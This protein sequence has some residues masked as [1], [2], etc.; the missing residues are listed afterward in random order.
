MGIKNVI[1]K[2]A[3][4][5]A[6][7]VAKLSALSPE[8]LEQVQAKREEFLSDFPNMTGA[9][10]EELTNRLLAAN[11]VEIYNAYLPQIEDLY[12]PVEKETEYGED[13]RS[14]NNIRYINITKWVIDKKE[15]SLEKLVNVYEVLSN[16]ACNISLVFHRKVIKT[17]VYLAVTNIDNDDN[18]VDI[19]SYRRRL[20]S[21]IQGN[22]P[23]SSWKE[24]IGRG[25]LPCFNNN[26][27][28]SVATASNV[29]TEKSE[30]FVSQTIEKLLDGIIPA[31]A[32]QE[33]ILVLLA[34][35]IQ[36]ITERKLI[37]SQIYSDLAPYASWQTNYTYTEADARG[38]AATVGI[39]VGASAG[40]QTGTNST[41]TDTSEQTDTEGI[42]DTESNSS[43]E[44]TTKTSGTNSSTTD[45]VGGSFN[46]SIKYGGK[47][48]LVSGSTSV[49]V[50]ASRARTIGKSLS[51]VFSKSMTKGTSLAKTASKAVS[52][53]TALATGASK[54]LNFSMNFGA[55]FARTSNVTAT[56][57]KNEGITQSF[58]NH[59]IKH[60]LELLEEQMKRL[61]KS[62]ALGMWDFAAYILSEDQTVAN[63]VA[64]S[65]L[66]LTQG[67]ESHMSQTVVNLWR[68]DVQ[69]EQAKANE[70]FGYLKDLRHPMFA[71][72][73]ELLE[74]DESFSVYP[75][76]VTATTALSGK[77]LAYSLNFPQKSIAG[78]PVFECAEF[79]RNINSYEETEGDFVKLGKI[80]HMN[81]TEQLD[82]K[83]SLNSLASHTFISGSTGTG[84]SNTVYEILGE[85]RKHGVKFL[86]VEPAKGEYK[87]IF[88][89]DENVSVYG[90]NPELSDL[91]RI[92]PFAFPKGIHVLEHLDRLIEIFNVCW[93]M[94]AAMPA[95]LKNAVERAYE[96]SGW[97]L[98]KSINSYGDL[99]PT[100]A[101][102]TRNI[103]EIIDS[104]EYDN[105]N[106]G[107]Y[108]GS[109][110][111]RLESLTNGI[112]G[113][114][115]TNQAITDKELFDENVII[116]LSRVGS[117]ETKSLIMG[118]LVLKL[119]EYRMTHTDSLNNLLKH[120]TVLEEA[121][122]ILKRTSNEQSM[123]DSNLV[124]KSVEMIANGI[125][126][127]RTYG[128]GFIIAD[129]A[130]GLM[131][132]AVIRNTNTKIIMRLPDFSD[133]ELVGKSA[134]LND[135]Q[136][137]ELA[138][139]PKGVAALY[140]N[141]WIEPILCK[142]DQFNGLENCFEYH[143]QV[144]NPESH[145]SRDI[146]VEYLSSKRVD[147]QI[148]KE[149]N[150]KR[151]LS[152]LGIDS[153]TVR[154][155][156]DWGR[157]PFSMHSYS[158]IVSQ[159]YP[160]LLDL[161]RKQS[162]KDTDVAT[163]TDTLQ[164]EINNRVSDLL[165]EQ[166]KRDL[167][168]ATMTYYYLYELKNNSA[169][170]DWTNNGGF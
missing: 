23:G 73:P 62:T 9:E 160:E 97:D 87:H 85:V 153:L 108:K 124:G 117:T 141:E 17:D 84:K 133:R 75:A 1:R 94:Y 170:Q 32:Q 121:H 134:N 161:L 99:Y 2:V 103:K 31:T 39:N 132:M 131:D 66:A 7:T 148:L 27:H 129:Q 118:M 43:T 136:I 63:N 65:Y 76:V 113:M 16:D 28:Y 112:N 15:N 127:M 10:T 107:A 70:I 40:T 71:L 68:G 18:N 109:L 19:E 26:A 47:G 25:K 59:N 42:T 106:K 4:K 45:T 37:L 167:L 157:E 142:I 105:E 114:I 151:F 53:S 83:I 89:N 46:Q 56:I 158:Q 6:D 122:N 69:E 95:V 44:G 152:Q 119:Q 58:T 90:T 143:N 55:N 11:A 3:G 88:G 72:N 162:L 82:A 30:K 144:T 163:M 5:G 48:S 60:A 61:E 54:A 77:E 93:P 100:F 92:N 111:T 102:V 166:A 115:F 74:N 22:F 116:D 24:E 98:L 169:F 78:L 126:E 138:K 137:T 123:E 130:P 20:E 147:E 34:T 155:I 51:K 81:H 86:V 52:K 150:F 41:V 120:V 128:E 35:P 149:I 36:D 13:F 57:G 80:F 49:G 164:N 145:F 165:S 91:L 64:Y 135:D 154:R 104:S 140:Q 50:N 33:Y 96:D 125:A 8:Q 159:L 38:S 14:S 168:Q 139:L 29:P 110:L 101:D 67:E 12:I 146:V 156:L 79:G 21:A